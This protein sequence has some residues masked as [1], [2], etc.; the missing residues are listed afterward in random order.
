MLLDNYAYI[1][2]SHFLRIFRIYYIVKVEI[3]I[4]RLQYNNFVRRLYI[5]IILILTSCSAST[6][7]APQPIIQPDSNPLV[8]YATHMTSPTQVLSEAL[9][10]SNETPLSS[11]TP[12]TYTVKAGDNLSQIAERFGVS[13]DDLQSANPDISAENLPVGTVLKIPSYLQNSSGELTPT[14]EPVAVR[15]IDCHPTAQRA[16]WCFVLVHNGYSGFLENISAQ[17]TLLDARGQMV[18]SQTAFLPLNILPPNTA[19]PLFVFFAPDIPA[20]A[21][22]R[23]QILT[24][25][26]LLPNDERYLPAT[27]QNILI[28]INWSGRSAEV[29]GQVSL[30]DGSKDA[31]LVWVAAVAYDSAGDVMGVRRWE[32]N[33]VLKSAASL[34]FKFMISSVARRIDHVE[35]VVEARP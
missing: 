7:G 3:I 16:M 33:T 17:V 31:R 12:F 20:D 9:I 1:K 4:T 5:P 24:A 10:F 8:P 22:P 26:H 14:P 35:V 30:P 6:G 2:I 13:L 23:V 21:N 32:S 29:S 11:P 28:E 27:L 19:L 18:A 25:I 15:E 34:P